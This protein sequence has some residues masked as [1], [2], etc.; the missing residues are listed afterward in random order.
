VTDNT[1]PN[2]LYQLLPAVFRIRDA[3]TEGEPLKAL[4]E[5]IEVQAD[6]A[7]QDI[8]GVYDNWFIETCDDDLVPYFAGLVGLDLGPSV[9]STSEAAAGVDAVWRRRQVANAI[10][11]RRRK[12]T[13]SVLEQL[14]VD[15]T[16]WPA[17]AIE[18][19]RV[20]MATQSVRF[21]DVGRRRLLDV[22]DADALTLIGSPLS[23]AAPL[24]DVR[25]SASPRTPGT[26]NP[27][28]VG[29]WLWRLVADQ[30]RCAPA[31]PT[32]D[33]GRYTFDQLGRDLQLA[34][35]P[36]TGAASTPSTILGV[37]MPITRRALELRLED[38]YGPGRSICVYRGGTAVPRSEILVADL[39]HEH[40][41]TTRTGHVSIDPEL[42]R[43]AFPTRHAPEDGVYV[44]YSRLGIGA[45]GGGDYE[46]QLSSEPHVY[47]VAAR[48]AGANRTI[49]A[50][51][52]AWREAKTKEPVPSAVIE[53]GD[54]GV[55]EER[56]DVDLAPGERLEIRA[57]QGRRPILMP[58]ASGPGRPDRFRVRGL[59]HEAR[60]GE[61]ADVVAT[62][63]VI[64]FDGVWIAGDPIELVGRLGG[65]KLR[66]CTL[67]PAVRWP[68]LDSERDRHGASI[69]V[70]AT[71]CPISIVSCVLGRIRVETPEAGRDLIPLSI[72]DSVLE[73]SEPDGRA[74]LGPDERPAW[75]SLSVQRVTVLGGAYVHS[76]ELVEDSIFT[77]PI[78]CERR[79]PGTVRYSFIP[80]GSRTPRRS[81]CQP[82]DGLAAAEA[83]AAGR[84]PREREFVAGQALER[85]APRFDGVEFGDAAY[86]RLAL[87]AAPELTQGAHD[88]GEM[89]AYHDL[90]Q[91][92]RVADLGARL[93]EF[94]PAGADI[95][96]RFAT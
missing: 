30:V 41:R 42:G 89:G 36:P 9:G 76:V 35:L 57:A 38:L 86:A 92:L 25:R 21:A 66:H 55:Y 71:P 61:A 40:G 16:G 31:A 8:A 52:K 33:D 7:A 5:A 44:T 56:F 48:T 83:A 22:G 34:V 90:W 54:D 91:A 23:D 32:D 47:Q 39:G 93:Q 73:A 17:R 70:R 28:S 11:D 69:V 50:A 96:I 88:G 60:E 45:I 79:Q 13:F 87:D 85:L 58:R 4:L 94:T 3:T 14:A 63:P 72:T 51:L 10:A 1:P 82:D 49:G 6:A 18:L 53:I 15:A 81:R 65:V 74:L 75:V 68:G 26:V 78:D 67:V 43:I 27:G 77:A 84:P 20:V 64:V 19:D 2:D 62:P 59:D 95:D 24:P 80:P 37:A 12:G 46:R 29:V